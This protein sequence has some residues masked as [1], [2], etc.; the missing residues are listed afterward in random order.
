MET[1]NHFNFFLPSELVRN[2]DQKTSLHFAIMSGHLEFLKVLLCP[3]ADVNSKTD[4]NQTPLDLAFATETKGIIII[5]KDLF[6]S[7]TL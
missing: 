7:D 2:Q 4:L 5:I 6:D 3:V 1:R